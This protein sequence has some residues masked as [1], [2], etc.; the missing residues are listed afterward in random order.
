M[1]RQSALL[2][3]NGHVVHLDDWCGSQIINT[4]HI[5]HGHV[6]HIVPVSPSKGLFASPNKLASTTEQSNRFPRKEYARILVHLTFILSIS[7]L[8][9]PRLQTW[10]SDSAQAPITANQRSSADRPEHRFLMALTAR[11]LATMLWDVLG[12]L[13]IMIWWGRRMSALWR[14]S[15]Q[16]R[17]LLP[18]V[19][20]SERERRTVSVSSNL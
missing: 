12:S 10:I 16:R 20:D 4:P 3:V 13:I 19:K 9:L 1:R 17:R 2:R 14:P 15:G 18:E 11:P 6:V 8:V 5:T 7:F